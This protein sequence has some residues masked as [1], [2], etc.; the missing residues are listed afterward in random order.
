MELAY[1]TTYDAR[2]LGGVQEW[3]GTGYYI[4]Q[5]LENQSLPLHYIGPL[6]DPFFLKVNRAFQRRYYHL[7][8]RKNYQKDADPLTL[9][10]Y[11]RQIEQKM[12]GKA[13]DIVF[14]ATANPIAY[15]DCDYPI[16]FWAD[17]TFAAIQDFYPL[18]RNLPLTVIQD[19]HRMEEMALQ[20][21]TLAI[22]A[23]DWAATSAINDYGADPA[24]VRVVPFGANT[25]SP[26]TVET[27]KDKIA[28][29]PRDCCK[30]LF[31][32]VEWERKGG[33]LVYQV[34]KQLNQSGLKTELTIV[35]CHPPLKEEIPDFVNIVGFISKSTLEGKNKI[36]KLIAE[37]HFLIVPSLAE[38]YG[39][40]F[41]EANAFG[42]PCISRRVGG[43]PT[44][45]KDHINGF[46]FDLNAE[47]H[48]Y[49]DY[50]CQIFSNYPR[51][52][53]LAFSSFNEYES[54][55]NW[56]IAGQRVKSLLESIL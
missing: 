15:L 48:E 56:R 19:W 1:V 43:I 6:N 42:V 54:R 21:C 32:A 3:S 41:C 28:A 45:V 49:C 38:C 37:S 53:E 31:M 10:N 40:V 7:F 16:I 24:K 34:A 17:G 20:K 9:K 44:I 30:L 11:A 51:Y 18:Y 29:R 36:A 4:A 12:K 8:H 47:V 52:K 39:L 2:S 5:S 35:G 50:I 14:S 22:Y 25:H 13:F 27:I 26:F 33:D 55:L 46:L 23:S